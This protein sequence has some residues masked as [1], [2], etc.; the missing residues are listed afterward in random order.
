MGAGL[1]T[2]SHKGLYSKHPQEAERIHPVAISLRSDSETA[3]V[4]T[5]QLPT[6][7]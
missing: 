5:N 1:G 7:T 4:A 2:G 6:W 3:F